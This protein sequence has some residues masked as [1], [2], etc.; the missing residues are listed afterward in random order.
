[1]QFPSTQYNA[2]FQSTLSV[3][4]ATI[5]LDAMRISPR[6]QSTLSVRRATVVVSSSLLRSHY[7]NP[8]SP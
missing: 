1:M 6:F 2:L 7:F 4:R 8:R 5:P 3:R